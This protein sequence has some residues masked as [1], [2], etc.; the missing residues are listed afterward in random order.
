MSN[1]EIEEYFSSLK[2]EVKEKVDFEE[3]LNALL[4]KDVKYHPQQL[5]FDFCQMEICENMKIWKSLIL[6]TFFNLYETN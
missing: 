5:Y 3:K 2:T 1:E 4:K 6:G